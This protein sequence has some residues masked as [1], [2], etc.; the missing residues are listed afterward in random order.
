MAFRISLLGAA[1]L[2]LVPAVA[3]ADG[4]APGLWHGTVTVQAVSSPSASF[5]APAPIGAPFSFPVLVHVAADGAAKLL[6]EAVIMRPSA[7]EDGAAPA[8]AMLYADMPRLRRTLL[9]WRRDGLGSPD[10]QRYSSAAYDF[11]SP[12]VPMDGAA[13]AGGVLTVRFT[14]APDLPTHPFRHQYHPDHDNLD[15]S[16]RSLGGEPQD[17]EIPTIV[18][19]MAFA[20][21]AGPAA[22]DASIGGGYSEVIEGLFAQPL[23]VS[24][25][26]Q[27]SHVSALELTE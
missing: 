10:G 6:K 19:S 2:A 23:R 11:P 20:I 26:F 7:G 9:G 24:G 13:E 5:D 1:S 15:E 17:A 21:E 12:T 3:E 18:R 27:A 22:G 25:R 16:Y 4:I 14:L 8:S